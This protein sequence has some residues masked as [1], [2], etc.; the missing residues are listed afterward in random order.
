[1]ILN[2][3]SPG[4]PKLKEF[5]SRQ[6]YARATTNRRT[7]AAF[8]K[9]SELSDAKARA[10]LTDGTLPRLK[11]EQMPGA[12]GRFRGSTDPDAIELAKA[13]ADTFEH[14]ATDPDWQLLVESTIL[15]ELVHWGDWKDGKD[16]P[17]EEGKAFERA[18][19]GRDVNRPVK[20]TRA[21][22]A[23]PASCGTPTCRR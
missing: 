10:A 12:N 14:N 15:H 21:T 3:L 13:V 2:A 1:M 5:V 22:A 11:I 4:Y 16:Q 18:A 6:L 19:Y 23:H 7:W 20:R 17:G 8:L 9:Y